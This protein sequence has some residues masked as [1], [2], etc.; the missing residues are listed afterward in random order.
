[1]GAEIRPEATA[2]LTSKRERAALAVA[3]PADP[4]RQAGELHML[5]GLRTCSRAFAIQDVIGWLC[6][7]VS[8]I[9]SSIV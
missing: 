2:S 5:A 6:E 1:M 8:R 4:R 9:M 3:K 7:N